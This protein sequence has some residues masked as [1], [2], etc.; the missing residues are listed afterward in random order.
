[1]LN[2]RQLVISS[3]SILLF[4]CDSRKPSSLKIGGVLPL[5][6]DGSSYGIAAAKGAKLAVD[7]F[8]RTRGSAPPVQWVVEDS[9]A[10]PAAAA[11]A[12]RKLVDVDR[13]GALIGDVTSAGTHAI[14]P[15]SARSKIPLISPA[16]S[17]PALSGASPFF[18]R[19]W[20]SDTYE[21]QVLAK[22]AMSKGYKRIAA[23]YSNDDYGA[24]FF[25]VFSRIADKLI[26]F[27]AAFPPNASDFRGVVT[28]VASQGA[29]AILVVSLP[30]RAKLLLTQL[31]EAKVNLPILATASIEDPQISSLSLARNIAFA[32]PAPVDA[33][34][35]VRRRFE[36]E[37]HRTYRVAPGVLAD[38]G[39]DAA[40]LLIAAWG[41]NPDPAAMMS[42]IKSRRDYDGASGRL[43]FTANGDVI[44][45]YRLKR[46]RPGGFDWV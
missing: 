26:L 5:T 44:K 2:R 14:V 12:A 25:K 31:A 24:G 11:T 7:L 27:S 13:V 3:A 37:Y 38:T 1:M 42:W 36:S 10:D 6:G 39:Y 30:E 15:I 43:S 45:P 33:G 4:G 16:A 23:I 46:S 35:P 20:P 40:S 41:A 9:R 8:N 34:A 17:D 29:D 28:R 22:Y 18:A 32:S 19:V 21:A